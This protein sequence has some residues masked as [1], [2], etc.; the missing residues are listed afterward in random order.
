MKGKNGIHLDNK[1]HAVLEHC[2]SATGNK[3]LATEL[4][5]VFFIESDHLESAE[6]HRK[7]MKGCSKTNDFKAEVDLDTV[8]FLIMLNTTHSPQVQRLST[9]SIPVRSFTPAGAGAV[10]ED[11]RPRPRPVFGKKRRLEETQ[12]TNVCLH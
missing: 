12:E 8:R 10:K 11:C 2:V 9:I 3:L 5:I 1:E 7:T 6:A 4:N